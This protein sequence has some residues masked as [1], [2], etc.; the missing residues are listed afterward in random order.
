[1]S[2]SLLLR[3]GLLAAALTV[4]LTGATIAGETI[5][6][7][8][9]VQLRTAAGPIESLL[10]EDLAVGEVKAL[11]ADSGTT[12]IASRGANGYLLEIGKEE[13]KLPDFH[14]ETLAVHG[15]GKHVGVHRHGGHHDGANVHKR[16]IVHA[17]AEGTEERVVVHAGKDG[18]EKRVIVRADAEA[19]AFAGDDDVQK[20]VVVRR[21]GGGVDVD[22]GAEALADIDADPPSLA[23]A[24][25]EDRRI[26]VTRRIR[27]ETTEAAPEQ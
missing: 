16:V 23:D 14:T 27:H 25:N 15:A 8:T 12:V 17:G 2:I 11:R 4:A 7:E 18:V 13:F 26:L 5:Q 24:G 19:H 9:R 22:S 1:M 6:T 21:H 20:I 3:R 10:L